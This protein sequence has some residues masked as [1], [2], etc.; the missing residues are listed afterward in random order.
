[1]LR[2]KTT[3]R[4]A[5]LP[6]LL[7][8][9]GV[10]PFVPA[11]AGDPP[12]PLEVLQKAIK[13]DGRVG[14]LAT[15]QIVTKGDRGAPGIHVQRTVRGP[16]N[17][18]RIETLAPASMKGRL[19]VSD[20]KTRWEFRPQTRV[21]REEKVQPLDQSHRTQLEQLDLVNYL[22]KMHYMG[23]EAVAGRDCHVIG[24]QPGGSSRVRK[25]V[26]VDPDTYSQLKW[27]R[28]NSQGSLSTQWMV[29]DIDY[30][31]T[32]SGS[33]FRFVPPRGT[34]VERP[35]TVERMPL[36]QAEQTIGFDAV[37]P[38]YVPYGFVLHNRGS[39]FSLD[40][41]SPNV[42]APRKKRIVE[43]TRGYY[44]MMLKGADEL[45]RARR[46]EIEAEASGIEARRAYW[47]ARTELAL[48]LGGAIP[49]GGE[50]DKR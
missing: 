13:S 18:R 14:Y 50:G 4:F 27:E 26:W 2:R 39:A 37:L 47:A 35:V 29:L 36:Q 16:N 21:V 20:G 32:P 49:G 45:L 34:T 30:S 9:A 31:Y 12:R 46:D 5:V 8:L 1:M 17:C 28:Y 15:V 40:P 24:V 41:N 48:A 3:N 38:S 44:N 42:V 6:L 25:K 23:Q 19:I 10:V 43:M 11:F 33:E 22:V 7:T